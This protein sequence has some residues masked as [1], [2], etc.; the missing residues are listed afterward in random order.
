VETKERVDIVLR[1][2]CERPVV[3]DRREERRRGRVEVRLEIRLV[4]RC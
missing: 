2:L 1:A 4:L 3:G